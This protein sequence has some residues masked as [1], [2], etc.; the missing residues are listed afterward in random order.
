LTS[1]IRA[2]FDTLSTR[3]KEAMSFLASGLMNKQVA[4]KMGLAEITVKIHR[5]SIM[6]KMHAK[7][8]ADLVKMSEALGRNDII[9]IVQT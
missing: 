5:G 6:R 3:E 1:D 2:C 7:S 8:F 4:E 9:S